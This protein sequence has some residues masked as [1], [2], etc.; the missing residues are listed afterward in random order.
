ME[1]VAHILVVDDEPDLRDVL[2]IL[3]EANHYQVTEAG[4]G[5][6]ALAQIL[7]DHTI[8]LVLLDVM[9]PDLTGVEI[10]RQLRQVSNLP[11]IFLTALS[12]D[13]DKTQAYRSGGDDY[14]SKPFSRA[15]LLLKVESQLRRYQV[16]QGKDRGEQEPAGQLRVE[17]ERVY[18]NG[19]R[20]DLTDKEQRIV[21]F[22]WE[23]R[24]QVCS[25]ADIYESVWQERYLATSSNTVMVHIL[26]LRKKLESNPAQPALIRTIWGKGYQID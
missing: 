3:L 4:T 9:L 8:D 19:A 22:L 10:C 20:V 2:R 7:A 17:N 1:T 18:W 16:Y 21:A 5:K 26:N 13:Q 6:E 12:K 15:E 25:V 24:G 23:H 14:L 11:V